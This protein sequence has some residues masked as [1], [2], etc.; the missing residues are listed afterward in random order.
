[1]VTDIFALIK[2]E[3][4]AYRCMVGMAAND[5]PLDGFCYVRVLLKMYDLGWAWVSQHSAEAGGSP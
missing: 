1:M 3:D 4:F 2:S 5:Y